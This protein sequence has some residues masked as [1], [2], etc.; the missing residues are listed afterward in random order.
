MHGKASDGSTAGVRL[1]ALDVDGTVTNSR[2]EI[3][4]AT[5][6]AVGRLRA[7]GIRVMLATGR[8]Y[9]DVLPAA[10]RLGIDS[11][12]VTTS[13]ALVKRPSDH[14]TL[15]AARFE[16]G[17]L[18][19]VLATIVAGGNEPI[20]FTD[21]FAEGFDF[22]CRRI[23]DGPP[24]QPAADGAGER[25]YLHHNRAGARVAPLLDR[26]PPG[27]AFAVF[28]LG[29]RRRMLELEEALRATWPDRLAL[30]TIKSPRYSDWMCEIA[31]AGVTKWSGVLRVAADW[32]IGP[33]EICAVGDDVNDL[34]MIRGAAIGVAMGNAQPA[35]LA[36]A[37]RV[38]ASHDDGGIEEVA[39]LLLG[40]LPHPALLGGKPGPGR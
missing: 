4:D 27:D 40:G 38:V 14:A 15:Y 16:P 22:F 8:R 26:E 18:A 21:S 12:L 31:P 34:P 11:P 3:T 20:V 33:G 28:A 5:C 37:D 6:R 35:V 13:G 25:V 2:H 9:R 10:A 17:V 23:D 29:D 19:G 24:P 30:H 39:E 32:G 36:A 1:L 7:A